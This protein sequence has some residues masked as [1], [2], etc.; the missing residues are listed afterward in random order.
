MSKAIS[1]RGQLFS[2]ATAQCSLGKGSVGTR[3]GLRGECSDGFYVLQ[4]PPGH[5]R[6]RRRRPKDQSSGKRTAP[7]W[8]GEREAG[9]LRSLTCGA[10]HPRWPGQAR[11]W[12][13]G[14]TR[15]TCSGPSEGCVL[16]RRCRACTSTGPAWNRTARS[17]GGGS[18]SPR[19]AKECTHLLSLPQC[20]TP[21]FE[22]HR[23][24]NSDGGT[25]ERCST[26]TSG[27]S[28]VACGSD[29]PSRACPFFTR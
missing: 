2:L 17:Q 27:S 15:P 1:V 7:T 10:W 11:E 3:Q 29:P 22:G 18:P 13:W 12:P 19:D 21:T 6:G 20:L 9:D 25:L 5:R 23:C 26:G 28:E 4:H 24:P 14:R 8:S 16:P